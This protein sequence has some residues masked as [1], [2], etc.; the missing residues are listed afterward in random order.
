MRVNSVLITGT[1]SGLG[2]ALLE[3]Y[4]TSGVK[5]ISVNRRR[6][7]E[8]HQGAVGVQE[9]RLHGRPVEPG[10]GVGHAMMPLAGRRSEFAECV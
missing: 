2:R 7:A 5:V 9:H 1:T 6:V 4:A 10:I 3:H 8:L